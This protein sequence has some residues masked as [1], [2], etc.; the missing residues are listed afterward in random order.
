[1]YAA[2][3]LGTTALKDTVMKQKDKYSA[4]LIEGKMQN[5]GPRIL[6]TTVYVAY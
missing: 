3:G 5:R 2:R 6:K 4:L 1:M